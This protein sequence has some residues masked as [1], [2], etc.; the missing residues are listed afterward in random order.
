MTK[1]SLFTALL[2]T[3]ILSTFMTPVHAVECTSPTQKNCSV[4]VR[5]SRGMKV[6]TQERGYNGTTTLRDNRGIKQ[7]TIQSQPGRPSCEIIRDSR[8]VKVGT[9]G[10]C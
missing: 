6:G 5:D 8:G 7:G 3:S 9:R 1:R 2:A 4:T 10:N